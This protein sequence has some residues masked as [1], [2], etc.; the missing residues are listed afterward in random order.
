MLQKKAAPPVTGMRDISSFFAKASPD[1]ELAEVA[2]KPDSLAGA[3]TQGTMDQH[4]HV[5]GEGRDSQLGPV[6]GQDSRPEAVEGQASL[7]TTGGRSPTLP[8]RVV[9][10]VTANMAI[11]IAVV[12]T[13]E[14]NDG[15]TADSVG[16]L[17][18]HMAAVALTVEGDARRDDVALLTAAL[19]APIA[20]NIMA[21]VSG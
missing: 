3:R 14:A 8:W 11:A 9:R 7:S 20:E 5:P 19:V 21:S 12:S 17:V 10:D 6:G 18:A 4:E 15:H 13:S 1:Q 16:A 2:S